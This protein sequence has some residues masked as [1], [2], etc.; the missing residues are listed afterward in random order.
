M[1]VSSKNVF[2][3][4]HERAHHF[5][6]LYDILHNSRQRDGRKDWLKR[7]KGFMNWPLADE[8]VR[9]DGKTGTAC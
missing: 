4:A 9:I 2:D 3:F 7:F 5:L 8:I 6:T 1:P